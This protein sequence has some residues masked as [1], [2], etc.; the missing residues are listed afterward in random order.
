MNRIELTDNA[1]NMIFKLSEGNPGA[2]RVCCECVQKGAEID[3]DS[4][5]GSFGALLALDGCGVYGSRIWML[6]KHVCRENLRN[7]IGVLR[8]VNLGLLSEK[9]L[10]AAIDEDRDISIHSLIAAVEAQL[11]GFQKVEA[12][13]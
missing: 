4:A 1:T 6:Y 2:V 8:A 12:A 10:N 3:K 7:F 11:P 13:I 9:K 5:W